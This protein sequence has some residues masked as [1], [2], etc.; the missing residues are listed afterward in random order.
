MR[1]AFDTYHPAIV[2]WLITG[3]IVLS[4]VVRHPAFLV[5]ALVCSMACYVSLK[6]FAA[7]RKFAWMV[8]LLVL[9]VFGNPVVNPLGNT[10]LFT[11]FGGRP[12]TLEALLYGC[13]T[14]TLVATMFLWF[15]CFNAAITTDKLSYLLRN[16]APA[17]SLVLTMVLR[18]VPNFQKKLKAFSE[19]RTGIG[20]AGKTGTLKER[21][22]SGGTLL[23]KL[24]SW[25]L[26][27]S[28]DTAA[29][30]TSR[31]YGLPG[32]TSYANYS[33]T[34]RDA[35]LATVA[36]ALFICAI[37]GLASGAARMEYIP[38]IDMA[39]FD[40]TTAAGWIGYTVFLALPAAIEIL[41][42]MRWRKSQSRI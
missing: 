27:G 32:R 35:V 23:A 22:V 15:G 31:G 29:S 10:V 18:L 4:M 24:T 2:F 9:V 17:G 21:A 33:F 19:A 14:G 16:I 28:Q 25:A 41:E 1:S 26:E 7:L 39:P 30:M 5:A 8:P 38:A 34:R 36:V 37:T 6:G 12:Y 13:A 20:L 42:Q 3:A 11:Y 40:A